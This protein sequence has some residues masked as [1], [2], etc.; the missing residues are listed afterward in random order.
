[1]PCGRSG[2]TATRFTANF[3]QHVPSA[4][5]TKVS[6]SSNRRASRL[7]STTYTRSCYHGV[8]TLALGRMSVRCTLCMAA[9]IER[10]H[11]R[12]KRFAR[13]AMM[14]GDGAFVATRGSADP[15]AWT[16]PTATQ[17]HSQQPS[18]FRPS[19]STGTNRI[20]KCSSPPGRGP[21]SLSVWK[22]GLSR[23]PCST[24]QPELFLRLWS[25]TMKHRPKQAVS[26]PSL[27]LI[28]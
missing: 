14:H 28:S 18:R 11:Q 10:E 26:G 20:V 4:S 15:T 1:M 7:E 3:T 27:E 21:K 13:N 19:R 25:A 17:F 8:I 24:D 23:P 22:F 9:R 2:E 6:P 5:T 16:A 12:K